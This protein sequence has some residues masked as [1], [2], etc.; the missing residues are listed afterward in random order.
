MNMT[1]VRPSEARKS[2]NWTGKGG[3]SRKEGRRTHCRKGWVLLFSP[4]QWLEGAD[5]SEIVQSTKM[6]PSTL[7][8]GWNSISSGSVSC[9]WH[10]V[11]AGS[12]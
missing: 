4:Q 10:G 2:Q 1:G 8:A 9:A 5:T 11:L 12:V 7:L 6:S 3:P